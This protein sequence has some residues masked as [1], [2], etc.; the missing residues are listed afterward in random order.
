MA[1]EPSL[2]PHLQ[3]QDLAELNGLG[4]PVVHLAPQLDKGTWDDVAS[5]ADTIRSL[6]ADARH[7]L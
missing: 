4:P 6:Q 5:D 2:L 7:I 1:K 3:W